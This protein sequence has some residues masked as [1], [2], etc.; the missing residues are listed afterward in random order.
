[1]KTVF[2]IV[3]LFFTLLSFGQVA[4]FKTKFDLP[5]ELKETSG[6][7]LINGK[8]VTHNDSG[9]VANLYEIDSLSGN[10]TRT[11]A[12]SNA[13]NVDWED[14]AQDN[15]HIYIGDFGNNNGN[16]TD[17]KIY[18]ILKSDYLTKTSVTAEIINFSYENQTD[19][20]TRPNAH[21]FD[22]EAFVIYQNSIFI[23]T[24]NWANL[25]TNV[26]KI[27]LTEGTHSAEKVSNANVQV[28]ITGA[29]YH[30]NRFFLSAYDTNAN[31]FIIYMFNE[32]GSDDVFNSNFTRI[33]LSDKIEQGSQI[34]GI[35]S[36]DD[37]SGKYYLSREF[38]SVN[39]GGMTFTFQQRL[40]EFYDDTSQLLSTQ[41]E[42]LNSLSLLPNP[43]KDKLFVR[44]TNQEFIASHVKIYSVLGKEIINKIN[45]SSKN[46]IDV[47]ALKSGIYL[48]KIQLE[49]KFLVTRKFIKL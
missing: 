18:K 28:L 24:K 5:E 27:P 16:R 21:N 41:N 44:N 46:E 35:T 31:P 22:A 33:P 8:I 48:I 6:L 19:F 7:L 49:N 17:L 37:F 39:Q 9:D 30:D 47:S 4:N 15:T 1:M 13:T 11:I 38:V 20:T 29:T 34:E 26:Y 43:A 14:L 42:F 25:Q 36:F 3:G 10:L 23:F 32:S 12:I 40:Y 45:L 2:F